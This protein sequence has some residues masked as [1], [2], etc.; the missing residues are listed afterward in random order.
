VLER[1]EV[2]LIEPLEFDGHP[3]GV[4]ALAWGARDPLHYEQLREVLGAA[5][6]GLGRPPRQNP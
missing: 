2:M 4:A 1:E 5:V 6:Y 3:V